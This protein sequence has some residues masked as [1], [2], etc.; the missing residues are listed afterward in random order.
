MSEFSTSILCNESGIGEDGPFS[1]EVDCEVTMFEEKG[2]L[3]SSSKLA[4]IN[5]DSPSLSGM[6]RSKQT[7]RKSGQDYNKYRRVRFGKPGG[8]ASQHLRVRQEDDDGESSSSSS[9]SNI[10]ETNVVVAGGGSSG[11][12]VV[13]NALRVGRC[14]RRL[15]GSK[16]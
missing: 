14:H 13:Q 1:V 16:V 5:N 8:K 2:E 7:L 15:V 9:E 6:V 3:S 10:S 12:A 4:L 11:N